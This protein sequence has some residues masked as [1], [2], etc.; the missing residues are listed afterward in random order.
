MNYRTGNTGSGEERSN[1][2]LCSK[3]RVLL[4]ERT[5]AR[6]EHSHRHKPK[7]QPECQAPC[8]IQQSFMG[9]ALVRTDTRVDAT[10]AK[11]VYFA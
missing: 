2:D 4:G 6:K 1:W 3:C 5:R 7:C 9:F 8:V 10:S 11:L